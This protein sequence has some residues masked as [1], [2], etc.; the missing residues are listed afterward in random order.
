MA[1]IVPIGAMLFAWSSIL[2]AQQKPLIEEI[3]V[4]AQRVEENLQTV[5]IAV[6]A[7]DDTML[8][9]RQIIGLADLHL[10]TPNVTFTP[11]QGDSS[12]NVQI[13][14]IGLIPIGFNICLLY[15]SPSPRDAHESRMPSSA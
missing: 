2:L 15:T 4:T 1:R 3:I 13:R 10:N 9:E 7:F 11:R 12:S 5:P 8:Q 6:S 14:G